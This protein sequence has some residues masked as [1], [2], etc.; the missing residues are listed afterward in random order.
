MVFF[1]TEKKQIQITPMALQ[2]KMSHNDL[3]ISHKM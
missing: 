1:F 3:G 2:N